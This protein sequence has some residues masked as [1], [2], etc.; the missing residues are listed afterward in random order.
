MTTEKT[1]KELLKEKI[2]GFQMQIGE[3]K[4]EITQKEFE[5][6]EREKAIFAGFFEIADAIEN[7][8]NNLEARKAELDKSGKKLSKNI[9]SIH[10]KLIRQLGLYSIVPISFPDNKASMES[11]KIIETQ[12]QPDLENETIIEIIKNGYINE[13][14]GLVMRKAE[15][16]TVLNS[17]DMND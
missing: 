16:V 3:L 8:Q 2:I 9:R 1:E 6:T 13:Q 15:V 4:L 7:L 10:R 5:C 17:D 12:K 14:D 11:C